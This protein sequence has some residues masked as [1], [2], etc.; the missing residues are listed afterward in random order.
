[1]SGLSFSAALSFEL[2][3]T[4]AEVEVVTGH[5]VQ[6]GLVLKGSDATLKVS[7]F[8][9]LNGSFAFSKTTDNATP[10]IALSITGTSLSAGLVIRGETGGP[11]YAAA[12]TVDVDLPALID[13]L[14]L[15]G[16]VTLSINTGDATVSVPVGNSTT[17]V[18]AHSFSASGTDMVLATP[19]GSLSGAFS[20]TRNLA[21][22]ESSI[23]ATGLTLFLGTRGATS[24]DDVGVQL[25]S[26]AL[27]VK[28]R[29]N[30]KFALRA[31]GSPE[32]VNMSSALSFSAGTLAA[33]L[34][35]TGEDVDFGSGH[36]V[37]AGATRVAGNNVTLL[38]G[39][40]GGVDVRGSFAVEKNTLPGANKVLGD[41]DD[42]TE[43]LVAGSGINLSVGDQAGCRSV[44]AARSSRC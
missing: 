21:T 23:S 29:S 12:G 19:V 6:K 16:H 25:T 18:S 11:T 22:G 41:A 4:G 5:T 17:D 30:G 42:A 1:V 2:N 8:L 28:V 14:T 40:T 44:W 43:L 7:G 15:T 13:G 31:S 35:T 24:A 3:S 10:V 36:T 37:A 20:F 38:V 33:E 32:L 34:N 9:D 26:T 39:G 27:D